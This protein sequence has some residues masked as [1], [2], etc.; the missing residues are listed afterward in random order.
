[1][2][3]QELDIPL[4][5]FGS[6]SH[7]QF[8]GCSPYHNATNKL[9][10]KDNFSL[11]YPNVCLEYLIFVPKQDRGHLNILQYAYHTINQDRS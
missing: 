9:L 10:A 3:Q 5:V 11:S 1:M 7:L 2:A 8:I 6:L 4:S